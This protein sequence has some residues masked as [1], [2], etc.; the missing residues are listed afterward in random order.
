VRPSTHAHER[1]I[2]ARP[3]PQSS[4]PIPDTNAQDILLTPRHKRRH[5]TIQRIAKVEAPAVE[6][7]NNRHLLAI[8]A[9]ARSYDVHP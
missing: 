2:L 7:H 8:R 9:T 1:N 5:V 6:I 4:K 3:K